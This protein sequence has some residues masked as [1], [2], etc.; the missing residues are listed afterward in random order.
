MSTA[1]PGPGQDGRNGV[2]APAELP[3]LADFSPAYFGMVM[4]TG[5]VSLLSL[6]HI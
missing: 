5:I 3:G 1:E 6:I 2:T 4:A